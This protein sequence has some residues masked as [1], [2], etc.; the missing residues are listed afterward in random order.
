MA[1]AMLL[2]LVLVVVMLMLLVLVV[3]DVAFISRNTHVY[4]SLTFCLQA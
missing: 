1:R 4:I 2:V 3:N